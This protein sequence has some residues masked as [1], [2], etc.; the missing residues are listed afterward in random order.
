MEKSITIVWGVNAPW[1]DDKIEAMQV[2]IA[3]LESKFLA[4][5][6]QQVEGIRNSDFSTVSRA[7]LNQAAAEEEVA[8]VTTFAQT[9][10]LDLISIE[11]SDLA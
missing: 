6:I 8:Y 2:R 9:Y 7:W 11:I 10:G 5:L 4:G 1:N 3:Y